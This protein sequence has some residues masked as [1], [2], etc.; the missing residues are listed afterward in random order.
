MARYLWEEA[1]VAARGDA[2]IR[3]LDDDAARKVIERTERKFLATRR[4]LWWW[5]DL[6]GP[7]ESVRY[8]S[9]DVGLEL[10]RS[11]IDRQPMVFL[12]VTDN[13]PQPHGVFSGPGDAITQLIGNLPLFE[14]AVTDPEARW[15]I[16]ESHHD[17]LY[18][19]GDVP[20]PEPRVRPRR[21]G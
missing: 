10:L 21:A 13:Q 14:Y 18:W 7:Y 19:V 1:Q 2:R 4:R 12:I 15:L 20:P 6:R 8:E 9:P 5:E 17:V 16:L 3:L 11:R